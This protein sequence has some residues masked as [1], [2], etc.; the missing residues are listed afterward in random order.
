MSNTYSSA[1]KSPQRNVAYE[2]ALTSPEVSCMSCSSDL[3]GF[4]DGR[5]MTVLLLFYGML[6][7]GF[8]QYGS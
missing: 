4:R 7:P 3:N 1:G 8:V 2:L 6:L 5:Y